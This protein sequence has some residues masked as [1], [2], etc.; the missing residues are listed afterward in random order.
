[1][2]EFVGSNLAYM[3]VLAP[4]CGTKPSGRFRAILD[5]TINTDCKGT[6][7]LTQ[8]NGMGP[9]SA[10]GLAFCIGG[11]TGQQLPSTF[12]LS[13]VLDRMVSED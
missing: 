2:S 13:M 6:H 10:P 3:V 11:S 8:R 12:T 4:G 5:L 7:F 9:C 1:M